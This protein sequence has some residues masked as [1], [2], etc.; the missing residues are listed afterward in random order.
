MMV[1]VLLALGVLVVGVLVLR[2]LVK[3]HG[4]HKL[5]WRYATG[6]HLDGR[7]RTDAGWFR[8]GTRVLHQSG[9]ASRWAHKPRW[10]RMA[11]RLAV[12]LVVLAVL[13]GLVIDRPVTVLVV[14]VLAAA[15]LALGVWRLVRTARTWR[16]N[17]QV[18][19]PLADALALPL[20]ST[21]TEV[22]R[23]LHVPLNYPHKE[24]AVR[25]ALPSHWQGTDMQ[26]ESVSRIV[27]Q[28]LGGEWT[29]RV[30]RKPFLLIASHPP[31]PPARVA[32]AE[33]ADL[34]RTQG[35]IDRLLVGLG[36]SGTPVWLD[37]SHEIAHLGVSVGTGGGKSSFLRLVIA[38][39]A[40]WGCA[41]FPVIDSKLIS[42]DGMESIP[43]MR[44][45]R[46]TDEQWQAIGGQVE[47]M[48]GRY[49][50]LL[51]DRKAEFPV[52]AMLLE[53]QNDAAIEWRSYWNQ[54]PK[55]SKSPATP[56]VYSDI[57]K[58]M[59]KGRQVRKRV[60]G[61]YQM[62]S[63]SACGGMDASVMRSSYGAKALSRYS[64]QQ[65]DSLTGIRP[66]VASSA[67]E[68]RWVVV[69][70]NHVRHVQVPLGSAEELC[71]F[72]LSSPHLG[73]P[74]TVQVTAE[75]LY[76]TPGD[77]RAG[78]SASEPVEA[79]DP[80]P[81]GVRPAIHLVR[82]DEDPDDAG[83]PPEN[84]GPEDGRGDVVVGRRDAANAVGIHPDTFKKAR[85]R[86]PV[87]GEFQMADGRPAWPRDALMRWN[88]DRKNAGGPSA[89]ANE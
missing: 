89:A 82:P 49:Q 41:D 73:T 87:P 43:G 22:E 44:V 8:R 9:H 10:R 42:L 52:T 23:A 57:T 72:A 13:A 30:S 47:E 65:W 24:A 88:D 63:H 59:I 78:V 62:L 34:I 81:P 64:H 25:V 83:S 33:V 35:S 36:T 7:I 69:L 28:R 2:A 60:I 79:V 32:F 85:A 46:T 80:P 17:R 86:H 21:A 18:V 27:G 53:E 67:I 37:F 68:G 1:L 55:E 39:L 56:P 16:H 29:T 5:A 26:R 77:P 20:Q 14:L 70:G 4:P 66:R 76:D 40:Y 50:R 51:A 61:V 6:A 12:P 15:G 58:Y 74:P 45:Y 54:L 71:E 31:E 38:Q 11:W 84:P 75:R 48:E 19:G 3:E